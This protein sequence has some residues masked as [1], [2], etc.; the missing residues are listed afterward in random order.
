MSL[1]FLGPFH[2]QM[3]HA[4]V[5]MLIFSAFLALVARLYDREWLRKTSVFM[6]V[7]GFLGAFL[8][9]QSG[10][11]AHRVPEHQQG[12][13]EHDIDEHGDGG[14][15]VLYLSGGALVVLFIA[16]RVQ[17][18]AAN[19]LGL[20]ALVIQLCAAAAVGV[21]AHRGGKLVYEHGANVKVDGQL[22]KSARAATQKAEPGA[23]GQKPADEH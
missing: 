15:W 5:V 8:A 12:V 4:P 21:T 16:A 23:A 3:V 20:L 11:A 19:A 13:P 10:K 17:G 6:L 1:S 7:V 22:V 14:E 2:P 9:V 18:A